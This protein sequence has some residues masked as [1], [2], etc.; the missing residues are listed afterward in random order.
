M[1][2]VAGEVG[3]GFIVHPF[4]TAHYL[5]ATT[6][7]ALDRGLARRVVHVATSRSRFPS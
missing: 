3:D 6:L 7:P 4:S 1:T 2:E 5:Q